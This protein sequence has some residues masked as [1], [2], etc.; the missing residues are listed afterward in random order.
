MAALRPSPIR[1]LASPSPTA[2]TTLAPLP[3]SLAWHACTAALPAAPPLPRAPAPRRW[4][5][6]SPLAS[7]SAAHPAR[8]RSPD[9]GSPADACRSRL[10]RCR[11]ASTPCAA[12]SL[13]VAEAAPPAAAMARGR[14][15]W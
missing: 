4:Q 5:P 2:A 6:C 3:A 8:P 12:A 9:A 11:P 14:C 15:P 1:A 7:A 13:D 10:H